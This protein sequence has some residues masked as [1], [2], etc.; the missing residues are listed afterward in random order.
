M[1]EWILSGI[2]CC[3]MYVWIYKTAVADKNRINILPSS[4]HVFDIR[5]LTDRYFLFFFFSVAYRDH[6]LHYVL[7]KTHSLSAGCSNALVFIHLELRN[8]FPNCFLRFRTRP[9]HLPR[10][11]RL[12]SCSSPQRGHIGSSFVKGGCRFNV[13]CPVRKAANPVLTV[14]T[15]L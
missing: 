15:F 3:I 2:V 5:T 1:H 4:A 14:L 10:R 7:T 8:V 12:V 11:S 13:L 6:C 9:L